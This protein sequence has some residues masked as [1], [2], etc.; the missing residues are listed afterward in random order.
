MI[1]PSLHSNRWATHTTTTRAPLCWITSDAAIRVAAFAD[2][3]ARI[4]RLPARERAAWIL[5]WRAWQTVRALF[6]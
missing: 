6:F 3:R 4:V 2:H 5:N 1:L